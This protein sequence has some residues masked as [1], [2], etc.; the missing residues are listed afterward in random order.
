MKKLITVLANL[1]SSLERLKLLLK[2][3]LVNL[4]LSLLYRYISLRFKFFFSLI[5]DLLQLLE[6]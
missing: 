1:R 6:L 2:E 3:N 5:F 4:V